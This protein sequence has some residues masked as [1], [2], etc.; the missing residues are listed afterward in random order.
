MSANPNIPR[1]V[2]LTVRPYK[3]KDVY[4]SI[5]LHEGE[6]AYWRAKGGIHNLMNAEIA[7][8][9]ASARRLTLVQLGLPL[10]GEES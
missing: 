1:A 9:M 4:D 10:P 5:G 8:A 3:L 7:E 6:A 2:D